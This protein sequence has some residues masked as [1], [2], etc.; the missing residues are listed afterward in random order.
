MSEVSKI[1]IWRW[2]KITASPQAKS[3]EFIAQL[4]NPS[5]PTLNQ[6]NVFILW[7]LHLSFKIKQLSFL[8]EPFLH[9][10]SGLPVT[11]NTLI[12]EEFTCRLKQLINLA[13]SLN[14][15]AINRLTCKVDCINY[16]H[17]YSNTFL[18]SHKF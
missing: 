17:L 18:K 11:N 7:A 6:R 15:G 8:W 13:F 3:K 4:L 12:L 9:P 14:H 10:P 5:S 2:E 16:L 1:L